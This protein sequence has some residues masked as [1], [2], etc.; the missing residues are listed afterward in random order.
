M[1]KKAMSPSILI[2]GPK[3]ID[4]VSGN[5]ETNMTTK[6]LQELVRAQLTG[7]NGW[8]VTSVAAEG[9]SARKYCY[10][11][12]GGTLYVTIPD[13]ASVADIRDKINAVE[14]GK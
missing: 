13:E 1:I 5:T 8:N 2:K 4:Q 9:T 12:S 10:S 11:Y 14:E 3:L 6:Q 7:L